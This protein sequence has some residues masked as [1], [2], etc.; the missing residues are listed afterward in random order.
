ME[1]VE[2]FP[3]RHHSPACA[4]ALRERARAV[5]PHAV[6]IEG[7]ADFNPHLEEL[8]LP[9]TL[10]I[11]IYSY[12]RDAEG[13][14]H[15]AYYPFCEY[16]PEWQALQS[17]R[18]L[19]AAARFIDLPWRAILSFRAAWEA[20]KKD[21]EENARWDLCRHRYADAQLRRSA[22]V[23]KLC[24]ELGVD[25]F[26]A[27]WDELFEIDAPPD[28]EVYTARA[29]RFCGHCRELDEPDPVDVERE[30]FMARQIRSALDEFAGP[31]MVATG[32][33]HTPA[34]EQRLFE[35]EGGSA[36]TPDAAADS[37]CGIA[38]TPYSFAR[39]DALTGYEAGMP[40]PGFYAYVWQGRARGE[41]FDHHAVLAEVI[42][43]LRGKGQPISAADLIGAEV[44]AQALA[45]LRG[46]RDIWRRDMIDGL[47]GSLVKDEVARGGTHPLL[48]A[49]AEVF[50]GSAVGR[51]AEGTTLP[52]LV[53][54]LRTL[55]LEHRLTPEVQGRVAELTLNEA[56]GRARSRVLHRLRLLRV[57]GFELL[58][59][60]DMRSRDDLSSVWERWAIRWSP[61]FEATGI[62]AARYGPT[63]AEA[64]AALLAERAGGIERDIARAAELLVDA[65]LA[66]LGTQTAELCAAL[67]PL[68]RSGGDFLAMAQALEHLLYLYHYDTVLEMEH[69][70]NL[71]GILRET[72]QR[73]LWLL[74]SLG[75]L[76]GK[77][78]ELLRAM[79]GIVET[80]ERC[81]GKLGLA[82]T[83]LSGVL[84]RVEADGGQTALLRGAAAGVLWTLKAASGE[85]LLQDLMLFSSPS[86]LGDFL[87][88][89]FALAREAA[90]REP[91]LLLALDRLINGYRDTEFLEAMPGLRLAFTSFTPREKHHIAT[92]LLEQLMTPDERR[93]G[94]PAP[95]PALSVSGEDI[96]RAIE[97]EA[98]LLESLDRYG[99]RGG[100]HG[101]GSR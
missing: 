41:A 87:T 61:D 89:L 65:A 37:E 33:Y 67:E 64:A 19:G 17:A 20:Q 101:A 98:R 16:S 73:C 29:R 90:Q 76:I 25:D 30:I 78:R 91:Q 43:V 84:A 66:G 55:L 2:F 59:G 21:E 9:H 71:A 51:L 4:R 63:L 82:G 95:L 74:E 100:T 8:Y 10:P 5:K 45:S 80:F 58:D 24:D 86:D 35:P 39:L 14:R 53:H 97:F 56:V 1:R 70:E 93:A 6:L 15:G 88:G 3:I 13:R 18:E 44:T 83:E 72:W 22:Y 32:G 75:R 47:R 57:A 69:R 27:L 54:D 68:V 99:I 85:R 62:E 38:L 77:D 31:V 26:D 23:K 12:V 79:Q 50:R 49:V 42:R 92:G 48:E 40:G 46:H 36:E 28:A 60:T 94:R 52:P 11:A 96:A 7:P 81:D 34:L